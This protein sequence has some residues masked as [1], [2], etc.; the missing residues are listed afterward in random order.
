MGQSHSIYNVINDAA[1]NSPIVQY[2]LLS[3]QNTTMAGQEV[4]VSEIRFVFSGSLKNQRSREGSTVA[5]D[6][7]S[8]VSKE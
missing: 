2:V 1:W 8:R 7:Y 4:E 5:T 3:L 6:D